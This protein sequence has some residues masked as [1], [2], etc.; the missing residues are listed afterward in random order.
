[1]KK[2]T[3]AL[4]CLGLF[5]SSQNAFSQKDSSDK[6]KSSSKKGKRDITEAK[7][8]EDKFGDIVKKSTTQSGLFT[9]HRDTVTG[10]AYLEI[11]E[12]QFGKEF[13]YF[14]HVA[15][16]PVESGYFRGNFGSSKII[17]FERNFD[18]IDII[19]ENTNYY[20]DPAN[21]ISKSGDAN[22]NDP[23]L[24][25]EK[26]EGV[27]TDKKK[28]LIDGDAVFLSEKFQ[29]IKYPSPP[30]APPG[31]LGNLSKEKTRLQSVRNYPENTEVVV[32]YVYENASPTRGG[33][34]LADA[35]NITIRYQ[36]T[37][38]E[39][40]VN[41]FKS[42]TDDPRIGYF[43]TQ[44]TDLTSFEVAN[45]RDMIHRWNLVKKNP[46][47]AV[48]DPVTPI[49]FWMENTTPL[50]LR[51]II[52][53]ACESWNPAFEKAGFSNAVVCLEQPDDAIWD[54]GDIRYNVLRW[55]ST[56]APPFG[57][58]GPSF[59]NP[60]TG[61][62]IGADIML[63]LVSIINR[64]NAERVFTPTSGFLT[65]E[66]LDQMKEMNSRNPFFC[67]AS[68]MTNHQMIFGATA[69]TAFGMDKMVEKEIVSQLLERLILH[70]VGHTLGLTHNMRASTLQSPADVKNVQKIGEEGLANSIM[71]YPAFNYQL[72][73]KEQSVYCDNRP[74]P[75]DFWVIEYGYSVAA[76]DDF[77]EEYRLKR[78]ADRSTD[79]RL[80]YGNDADDMRSSGHGIDPDV[81]IYDLTNDPV[82][83]AAERCE[84][85]KTIL[86]NLLDKVQENNE[87]YQLFLQSYMIA[88]GEY[89]NQL[90]VM[91]RQI[92]GV[93]YD[94]AYAGQGSSKK[95]LEAVSE[96]RQ[97]AAMKAL[98]KY[99]FHP[100]VLKE[101]TP[102][103]NYLLEQRRGFRHGGYN[104]DPHVHDRILAMQ[105]E[106]FSQLLHP[107]VLRRITDSQLY[108]NTYSLDEV[109]MD[110]TNAIF[111][112]DAKGTVNTMRQNLQMEYV[113]RLSAMLGEK[114]EH[115]YVS[116]SMA[117]A[118][119]KRIDQMEAAGSSPDALTKAHREHVRKLI[120]DVMAPKN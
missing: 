24:A 120:A 92:G 81:N 79:P 4:V 5:I 85:V 76:S 114:S 108:G 60:R 41:D 14:N 15:D 17:R 51:S 109:M 115:D 87:S 117:L 54:A 84:L 68:D 96:E 97:K 44:V 42:R 27:S 34:A 70:E 113:N 35:R 91:T 77:T 25:S 13:I 118:E 61:E 26:I 72:N 9:I 111:S 107:N 66:K 46:E 45:Y 74:G 73:P 99:A 48:S 106:C 33:A 64:V 30:G 52:K 23:V 31:V 110:L 55:T 10:K 21:A 57:G 47:M 95:P 53:A 65:D 75:Y 69:A 58:Y 32:S 43:T 93:H 19:Q 112:G 28:Y 82:A 78:I 83:Y 104:I 59:V 71:E 38:L 1:M 29:L 16:A 36:H 11:Q 37:L 119:L 63:E 3:I 94:R 8:E 103:L 86:P 88:T 116:K 90:R 39:V 98:E 89:G 40:P 6:K 56:P 101:S 22:I 105:S 49:T 100:D 50:E 12:N 102:L 7:K 18:K 2:W 20:F 62:I 80:A 67:M